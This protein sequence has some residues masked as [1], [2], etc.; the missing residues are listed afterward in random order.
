VGVTA[1]VGGERVWAFIRLKEGAEMSVQEVLDYCREALEPYKIPSQVRFVSQFP[2]AET[3]KPQKFQLRAM[4]M[5]ELT[6]T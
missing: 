2:E 6:R 1:A 5:K 4:A 3:G